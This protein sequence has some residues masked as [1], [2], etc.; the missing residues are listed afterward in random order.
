M[1]SQPGHKNDWM[2]HSGLSHVGAQEFPWSFPAALSQG[3]RFSRPDTPPTSGP[4]SKAW[5]HGC[6][7]FLPSWRL[8]SMEEP[9]KKQRCKLEVPK[10]QPQSSRT[11]SLLAAIGQIWAPAQIPGKA[12]QTLLLDSSVIRSLCKGACRWAV[13]FPSLKTVCHEGNLR[14]HSK[15]H[16]EGLKLE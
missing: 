16:S 12:K 7:G 3:P 11:P 13:L 8:V 1:W 5:P 15:F 9:W 10:T 2:V 14:D 4:T 6:L